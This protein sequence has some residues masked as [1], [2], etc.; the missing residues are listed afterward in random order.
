[1]LFLKI[2]VKHFCY[3]PHFIDKETDVQKGKATTQI[4]PLLRGSG[5]SYV[6]TNF[7][8]KQYYE[9]GTIIL[10][11]ADCIAVLTIIPTFPLCC[12]SL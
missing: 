6:S 5:S 7:I 3:C 2:F 9:V 11:I 1:M 12:A 10:T 4:H 8:L